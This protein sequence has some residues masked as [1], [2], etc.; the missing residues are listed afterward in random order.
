MPAF[1][2]VVAVIT[3][4]LIFK[5]GIG[6]ECLGCPDFDDDPIGCFHQSQSTTPYKNKFWCL[7]WTPGIDEPNVNLAFMLQ[8]QC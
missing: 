4:S 8:H 1:R 5:C 2:G 3:A 6:G 7:G